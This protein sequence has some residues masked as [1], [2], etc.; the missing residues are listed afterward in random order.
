MLKKYL[1][2]SLFFL[3]P[4]CVNAGSAHVLVALCDNEYQ[5]IVPVPAAI[6]KG[7]DAQHNL[8]WGAMYGARTFLRKSE[9]WILMEEIKNPSDTILVRSVFKNKNTDDFAVLDAYDGK[10]IAQTT[11]DFFNFAAGLKKQKIK[12]KDE[13]INIAGSADLVVYL[14]HNGL[15]DFDLPSY[16]QGTS[17]NAA[18]VLACYSKIYFE[19]KLTRAGA[20]PVLLTKSKMAPEGYVLKALL[21]SWAQKKDCALCKESAAGAY[22]KYQ[23]ITLKAAKSVF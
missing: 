12:I 9:E 21:D 23:N 10:Y 16:P 19:D 4:L 1:F 14:G 3:F 17:G 18:A 20:K 15:M 11:D 22:A 5:G 7:D 8:Y 6:G 13:E 2:A